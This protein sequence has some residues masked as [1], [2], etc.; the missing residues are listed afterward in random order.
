MV[1]A[2][3]MGLVQGYQALEQRK[4]AKRAANE[5]AKYTAQAEKEAQDERVSQI[6]A[7]RLQTGVGKKSYSTSR[8]NSGYTNQE[9]LG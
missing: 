2:A 4:T 3:V 1:A 5:Q 7:M 8:T 6:D 9:V